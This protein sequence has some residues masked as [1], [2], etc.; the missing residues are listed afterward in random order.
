MDLNPRLAVFHASQPGEIEAL[1]R[2][3]Q[4]YLRLMPTNNYT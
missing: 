4:A 3:D 1:D 2:Q